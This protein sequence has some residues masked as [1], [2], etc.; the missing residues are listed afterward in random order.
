MSNGK[1]YSKDLITTGN[2]VRE[3]HENSGRGWFVGRFIDSTEGLRCTDQV[4]VKWGIHL[5]DQ[6]K[7]LP[8]ASRY[9]TTLT[10]LINGDFEVRFPEMDR[11][12]VLHNPGDY[13]MF[14]AGTLHSWKA[15]TDSV[16]VTVRWPSV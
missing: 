9:G 12:V 10:L 7:K 5:A 3:G 4:E 15:I 6:G 2:A 1:S 13:V 11:S 14:S 8:D 16:V